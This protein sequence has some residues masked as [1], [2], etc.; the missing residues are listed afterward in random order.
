MVLAAL[1][2]LA[3]A[4]RIDGQGRRPL[5]TYVHVPSGSPVDQA[6]TVTRIFEHFAPGF[7]DAVVVVRSVPASRLAEHNANLA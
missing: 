6:D 1:P 5:W 3:D 7:R 4:S 2:H